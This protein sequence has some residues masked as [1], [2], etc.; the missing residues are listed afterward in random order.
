LSRATEGPLS[1]EE[2]TMTETLTDGFDALRADMA[3]PIV[4]PDD[5]GYEQARKV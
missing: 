2:I 5:P 4:T 3:G 1:D